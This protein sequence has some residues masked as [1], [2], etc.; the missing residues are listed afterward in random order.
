MT[1]KRK[2]R[3]SVRILN[4]WAKAMQ[5]TDYIDIVAMRGKK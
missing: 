5:D 1:R 4:R 2:P 3:L